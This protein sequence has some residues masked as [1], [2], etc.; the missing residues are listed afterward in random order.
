[1][2][3]SLHF[4]AGLPAELQLLPLLPLLL[5]CA[6]V[7]LPGLQLIDFGLT[8]H[9]ESARTMLVGTPGEPSLYRSTVE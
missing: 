4:E 6:A 5:R 9:I 8:K 7:L 3:E 2:H 1:L